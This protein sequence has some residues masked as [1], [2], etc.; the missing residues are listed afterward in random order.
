[1]QD[2]NL[3]GF[4]DVLV[5]ASGNLGNSTARVFLF[6]GNAAGTVPAPVA[7]PAA[8]VLDQ[9]GTT[10]SLTGGLGGSGVGSMVVGAQGNYSN[11]PPF[12]L[13]CDVNGAGTPACQSVTLNPPV[14]FPMLL[15]SV[16]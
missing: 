1:M 10:V 2:V 7:L 13:A 8:P 9:L 6:L 16:Q 4:A 15:Q 14:V 11:I 5:G 3:D 12:L